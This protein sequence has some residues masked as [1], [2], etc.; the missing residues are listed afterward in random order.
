M[1]V[2]GLNPFWA[3]AESEHCRCRQQLAAETKR[4][5][6]AVKDLDA[7]REYMRKAWYEMNA[8]R[9][10]DGAPAGVCHD[11]WSRLVDQLGELLGNDAKPWMTGA[12]LRGRQQ[13]A[14]A[15]SARDE[16]VREV[17][18][19][20]EENAWLRLWHEEARK[21]LELLLSRT[22]TKEATCPAS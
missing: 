14:A 13:L 8:I 15:E 1:Y 6:E 2:P 12:S 7:G 21:E 22:L 3:H 20:R 18:R 17:G 9:A 16:A 10:R 4:A 11:Y 19:L 5:D